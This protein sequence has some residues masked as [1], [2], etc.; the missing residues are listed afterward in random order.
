[1][2]LVLSK[3]LFYCQFGL[4]FKDHFIAFNKIFKNITLLSL[5]LIYWSYQL[6]KISIWMQVKND[7]SC[8]YFL[9]FNHYCY[10]ITISTKYK[11]PHKCKLI[12]IQRKLQTMLHGQNALIILQVWL[13]IPKNAFVPGIGVIWTDETT[14]TKENLL[15][16]K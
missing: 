10:L 12:Q 8:H 9:S 2:N 16:R 3:T 7:N 11:R 14:H 6:R 4:L 15:D 1:M 13:T 5:A